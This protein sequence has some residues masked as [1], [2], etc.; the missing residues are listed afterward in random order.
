MRYIFE[1]D[2][3]VSL[4]S[5]NET[6]CFEAII[7]S[8]K[9]DSS[10]VIVEP[11]KERSIVAPI[12]RIVLAGAGTHFALYCIYGSYWYANVMANHRH[13]QLLREANVKI[14]YS[15]RVA[16]FKI[17]MEEMVVINAMRYRRFIPGAVV[18]GMSAWHLADV[19]SS[20]SARIEEE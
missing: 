14:H 15:S 16:Q 19:V 1:L 2:S 3:N 13:N 11:P 7:E 12:G 6:N 17:A 8:L 10:D 9:M 5:S 20:R 4:I 18:L